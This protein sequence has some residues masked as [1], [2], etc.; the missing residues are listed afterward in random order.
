MPFYITSSFGG[1]GLSFTASV[2]SSS[3]AGLGGVGFS[4]TSGCFS[5]LGF[6]I[7]LGFFKTT[8]SGLDSSLVTSFFSAF[9]TD[10][11]QSYT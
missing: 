1:T 11:F 10:F 3:L 4:C 7:T 6:S 5:S 2:F 8:F 9:L